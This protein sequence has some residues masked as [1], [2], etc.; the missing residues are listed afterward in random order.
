MKRL[1]RR[2]FLKR[3]GAGVGAFAAARTMTIGAGAIGGTVATAGSAGAFEPFTRPLTMPPVLT[4]PDISLVA[5]PSDVQVLAGA[6]T[7]LWTF[8][9]SFPGPI[10]R[11]PSGEPTRVTVTNSLPAEAGSLTIHH[12]GSHSASSEDGQP[13][14]NVIEPGA[15]RTYTYEFVEDGGAERAALQWYHDHTH[16]NTGRNVWRGLAGM[17]IVDDEFEAS[18]PLPKGE[19]ELPLM[20]TARQFDA[21]NQLT[22]PFTAPGRDKAAVT[23]SLGKSGYPPFDEFPAS[24]LLVNGTPQPY[25]DVAARRYR[26]RVLN[27]SNFHPYNLSVVAGTTKLDLIQIGTESGLLPAPITRKEILLGPAERADLIV[28]FAGHLGQNLRLVSGNVTGAS[29]IPKT[30]PAVVQM[31]EFRVNREAVDDSSVPASLRPL[32]EWAA[33]ASS[34]PD[35]VWAF[36]LGVDDAGRPAW[37]VNGQAFDHQRID[38]RPALG[39]V[40]TWM[41][42]NTTTYGTSHYIHIHDVDWK[43]LSRNG[44]APGPGEDALKETFRL[45]PGEVVVVAGKFTDHLG[46]YM[47]HCHMLEHEDHGMM[48]TFE[49]VAPGA[50]DRPAE[51]L[52]SA[53]AA[54]IPNE[55]ERERVRDIIATARAGRPAP[56][57]LLAKGAQPR[58]TAPA[59]APDYLCELS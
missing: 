12:H 55:V 45:D 52:G 37:T 47:L 35:R 18:L 16:F 13:G 4:S 42:V 20:I 39:S 38:A 48:S 2:Q 5:Q 3:S 46:P 1:S 9:G 57:A 51:G 56:A 24:K 10:I 27:A 21:N 41:L 30:A 36:G 40:E 14:R 50:S 15:S 43:V 26:L 34:Q 23:D 28:D 11:R 49:V 44:A 19:F 54:S 17:F 8:N 6:P 59:R 33:G 29:S 53:L 32:P 7:R 31:L 25:A 22:N 58:A